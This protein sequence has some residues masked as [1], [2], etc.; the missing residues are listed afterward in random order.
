MFVVCCAHFQEFVYWVGVMFVHVMCTQCVVM[1]TQC[2]ACYVY[3]N[4]IPAYRCLGFC[5]YVLVAQAALPPSAR[6]GILLNVHAEEQ[7]SYQAAG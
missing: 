4:K 6:P 7:P 5:F 2:V 3:P 1:C